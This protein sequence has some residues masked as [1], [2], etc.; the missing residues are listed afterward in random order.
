MQSGLAARRVAE[1][2]RR[3]D[4][5]EAFAAG[6]LHD[7]GKVIILLNRP[8][9][10]AEVQKRLEQGAP[11]CAAVERAVLGFDH[12]R[13]GDLLLTRWSMPDGLRAVARWHHDP[14]KAGD[15]APLV[16]VVAGGQL[17][18]RRLFDRSGTASGYEARLAS[19]C[20]ALGLDETARAEL[21]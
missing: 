3:A 1:F 4:P 15:A 13:V 18:R 8:E 11:D 6:V 5:D 21:E 16:Q 12:T 19:Y 14:D 17:L 20:A 9:E 10:Y 2:T 7:I